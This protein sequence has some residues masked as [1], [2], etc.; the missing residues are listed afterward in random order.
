MIIS[1][2]G[3]QST[4]KSTLLTMCQQH[5]GKKYKYV[6]E[7]TRL[8]KRKYKVP[9]NEYGNNTTQCLIINQ[10]IINSVK[11][12]KN[13]IMDRCIIDGIVYT[14]WLHQ[15]G[16]VN[17]WVVDYAFEVGRMLVP[18]LD[19]IFHCVA[20]FDLVSDGERSDDT[21]FRNEISIMMNHI[22]QQDA[23][24]DKVVKLTGN[25][26]QRMDIIKNAVK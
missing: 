15:Q 16:Q 4:G 23:F 24:K 13:V 18:K 1:F 5:F 20:D 8:V 22:L 17:K 10:H 12:K 21:Q 9:I 19:L 11:Y 14:S 2:T 7:V 25:I 26:E 6:E 3:A